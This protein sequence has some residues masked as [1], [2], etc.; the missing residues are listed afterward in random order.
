[1]IE[2]AVALALERNLDIAVSRMNPRTFELS[3]D[4]LKAFY[5]PTAT[6]TIGQN[7]IVQLPRSQLTGGTSVANDT[8]TY[9]FGYTQNLRW[10]GGSGSVGWTNSRLDSTSSLNTFNPQFNSTLTANLTQPLLRNF[11][12]DNNRSQIRITQLNRDI[13]VEDVR[14]VVTNTVAN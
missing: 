9:N 3:V 2:E 7:N 5:L 11:T 13:S 1:K 4:A 8:T 10:G 14:S 6:S 12:T